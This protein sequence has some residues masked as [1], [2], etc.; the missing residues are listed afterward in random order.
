ML[1]RTEQQI[2]KVLGFQLQ[3][4]LPYTLCITYLQSLDVFAH[5]RAPELAKRATAYLNTALLS[6]QLLYLTHQPPSLATAAI[7]LAAKEIGI[8]LPDVEWWEVFD[9]DRE[10]LG[11]L[12]VGLLSVK[13][14]TEAEKDRWEGRKIPL[15]VDDIEKEMN[16]D[17]MQQT[18]RQLIDKYRLD[19]ASPDLNKMGTWWFMNAE[20]GR[21]W[22]VISSMDKAK[23]FGW[24]ETVNSEQMFYDLFTKLQQE[25][26]I[27]YHA[28]SA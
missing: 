16:S 13:S 18:W 28:S 22:D 5:E 3:V 24:T 11:F 12:V 19:N 23:K 15:T 10:E 27:P 21:E 4:A 17:R 7:Y 2:L 9:T 26:V 14:F 1:Y 8:K 6:P 20:L 25:Q